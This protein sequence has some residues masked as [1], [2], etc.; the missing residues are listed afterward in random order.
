MILYLT[1]TGAPGEGG[2][3]V[4]PGATGVL[5]SST[6]PTGSALRHWRHLP[7]WFVPHIIFAPVELYAELLEKF[8]LLG[9]A[10]A[11]VVRG[12]HATRCSACRWRYPL[13]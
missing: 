5:K 7:R 6:S 11:E 9:G 8:R 1:G 4:W 10:G 12:H 13:L 3:T 2:T